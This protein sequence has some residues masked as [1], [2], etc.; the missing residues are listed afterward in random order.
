M[1]YK[2]NNKKQIKS[3]DKQARSNMCMRHKSGFTCVMSESSKRNVGLH[4]RVN[5]NRKPTTSHQATKSSIKCKLHL[6]T[7]EYITHIKPNKNKHLHI[8]TSHL[9]WGKLIINCSKA[10]EATLMHT[11]ERWIIHQNVSDSKCTMTKWGKRWDRH[12]SEWDSGKTN[13]NGR[14]MRQKN[15]RTNRQI[16][17]IWPTATYINKYYAE[18]PHIINDSNNSITSMTESTFTKTIKNKSNE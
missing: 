11:T 16:Y 7:H 12:K 1:T 3:K 15:E 2:K 4:H 6:G 13:H 9:T 10:T 18:R 5:G 8:L 17:Y 14:R